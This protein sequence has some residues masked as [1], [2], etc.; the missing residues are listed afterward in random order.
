[1]NSTQIGA[2]G[3]ARLLYEAAKRGYKVAI[4]VG[5]DWRYDVIVERDG[6]LERVQVKTMNSDGDVIKVPTFSNRTHVNGKQVSISYHPSEFDWIV[7]FDI[8]TDTCYF[9]P[10]CDMTGGGLRLRIN[11]SKN[12][13]IK[14]VRWAKDYLKW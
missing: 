1:M 5:H 14:K 2:I 11:P 6:N 12:N 9:I 3:E 4:P 10:S 8:T 7:A 13:Q